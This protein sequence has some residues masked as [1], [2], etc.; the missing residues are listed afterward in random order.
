MKSTNI[1][2]G[3]YCVNRVFNREDT[4]NLHFD[5]H[6][7]VYCAQG[8]MQLEIESRIIFLQPTKAAWIPAGSD[9]FAQINS[10][11]TC[12][13]ILFDPRF[14]QV[15][16][17]N[18]QAIDLT[19]LARHMIL[20]C[21]RWGAKNSTQD[22]AAR[23]FFLALAAIIVERMDVPSNDWVPR[24]QSTLVSRA[25]DLTMEHH[26][27]DLEIGEIASELGTSDRTLSRR[28]VNETGM[29]WGSLLRRI[30]IIHAR[31]KLSSSDLSATRV[32][33]DVGY[34]S[35]SAFNRAFKEETGFTPSKFQSNF[36]SE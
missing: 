2:P 20:H 33:A 14:F 10:S 18:V 27:R 26:M 1:D 16:C 22:E 32:A 34:S 5:D 7:L 30:R 3:A 15:Q 29:K 12:C 17:E 23:N 11:I 35:Q 36:K 25:V 24:G 19:P 8:S 6:Y 21:Q 28:V 31:E 9:V 4:G 13:S